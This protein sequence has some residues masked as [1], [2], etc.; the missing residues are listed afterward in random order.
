MATSRVVLNAV[1]N[2]AT[3]I[4]LASRNE[5]DSHLTLHVAAGC[6]VAALKN[7]INDELAKIPDQISVSVRAHNSRQLAFPRSLEHWLASFLTDQVIYDPT[8]IL[9]RARALVFAA[10]TCRSK[11]GNGIKGMLFD[12]LSRKLLVL[13]RSSQLLNVAHLQAQ[14]KETLTSAHN[15]AD[16]EA[17]MSWLRSVEIVSHLPSQK[18]VP[19]DAQSATLFGKLARFVRRWRTPGLLAVA[20]SAA[21]GLPAAASTNA[22]QQLS[23]GPAHLASANTTVAAH[24]EY[25]LLAALAVFTDGQRVDES[26]AFGTAGMRAY[27]GKMHVAQNQNRR[28]RREPEEIGQVG[29]GGGGGA[30]PGS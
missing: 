6:N 25:G 12:P 4:F 29:G 21:A 7:R 27:F 26:N 8:M 30:G 11:F 17:D 19:I 1:L 2:E 10:K 24:D 13:V 20:I 23:G 14:I 28:R 9:G 5:D 22:G 3:P 15:I 18:L 16:T